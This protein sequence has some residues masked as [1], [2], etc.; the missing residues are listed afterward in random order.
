MSRSDYFALQSSSLVPTS[1]FSPSL[2]SLA[3]LRF[4]LALTASLLSSFLF[5]LPL[6]RPLTFTISFS[7][8]VWFSLSL[9]LLLVIYLVLSLS[10]CLSLS[11]SLP[12]THSY[13]DTF[14]SSLTP[15]LF[16][17]SVLPFRELLQIS[18]SSLSS[19]FMWILITYN[20]RFKLVI[21]A[22]SKV[23]QS[24]VIYSA[25]YHFLLVIWKIKS[26]LKNKQG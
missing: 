20:A 17:Y 1:L 14:I 26:A 2:L 16:H 13:T 24:P 23:T 10:I 6:T 9:S 12:D 25:T 21:S 22:N 5:K 4:L 3:L 18:T 11:L 15:L 19:S 7:L 8:S